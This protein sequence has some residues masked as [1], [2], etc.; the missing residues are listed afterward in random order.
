MQT[1]VGAGALIKH[2]FTI[3]MNG[4]LEVGWGGDT[5]E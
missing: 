1:S 2:H 4:K 5:F 3:T